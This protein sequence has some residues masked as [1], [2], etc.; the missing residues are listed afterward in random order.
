MKT[1]IFMLML[2]II[3]LNITAQQ[4]IKFSSNVNIAWLN[5]SSQN[6]IAIQ[7]INGI[8]Y[9]QWKAGIGVGID[10]YGY[11]TAP[12]FI[13]VRK[14]FGN[15]R[16]QPYAYVDIGV[17]VPLRTKQLPEKWVGSSDASKLHTSFYQD[18]GIGLCFINRK[19]KQ[20]FFISAGYS[21]KRFAYDELNRNPLSSYWNPIDIPITYKFNYYRLN[22][23]M[24]FYIK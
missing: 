9:K 20:R 3:S 2:S 1:T 10:N 17:S 12:L 4:K 24:G 21:Y 8:K 16:I 11:T 5:G 7:N 18:A 23:R 19:H 22:M 13:D 15:K 6:E 14:N